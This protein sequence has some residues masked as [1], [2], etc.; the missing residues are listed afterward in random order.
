LVARVL[1]ERSHAFRTSLAR[2]I[3]PLAASIDLRTQSSLCFF[4]TLF[5]A[6]KHG[7]QLAT[8]MQVG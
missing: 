6:K 5:Y 1:M 8:P 2:R 7:F 3:D 4:E